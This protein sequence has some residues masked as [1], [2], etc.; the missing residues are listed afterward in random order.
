MGERLDMVSVT[1]GHVLHED[2]RVTKNY[3]GETG[4]AV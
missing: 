2:D 4:W 1:L 3:G